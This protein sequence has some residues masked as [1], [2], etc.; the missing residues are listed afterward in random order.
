MNFF[1]DLFIASAQAQGAPGAGQSPL[2]SMIP[3]VLVFGVMYFFMIRP[4]KKKFQEEQNFLS[5]LGQG[6]EVLT[7]S[8][9]LGKVVGITEKLVTLEVADGVKMKVLKTHLAGPSKAVLNP[10]KKA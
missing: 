4:Q 10:E 2:M 5:K 9:I 3:I 8:G 7:K 1:S 6:E